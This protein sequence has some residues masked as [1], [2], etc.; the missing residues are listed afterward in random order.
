MWGA[1][2]GFPESVIVDKVT[3]TES[4]KELSKLSEV[5]RLI[6]DILWEVWGDV[7]SLTEIKDP[8]PGIGVNVLKRIVTEDYSRF[9]PM[10]CTVH[11]DYTCSEAEPREHIL[12]CHKCKIRSLRNRY[13]MDILEVVKVSIS[14]NHR[15]LCVFRRQTVDFGAMVPDSNIGDINLALDVFNYPLN[16][17]FLEYDY[18]SLGEVPVNLQ[19]QSAMPHHWVIHYR[20]IRSHP[21]RG[22]S[23][24]GWVER[25]DFLQV[26]EIREIVILHP[27]LARCPLG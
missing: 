23:K 17:V 25:H 27:N 7:N 1:T 6:K 5:E 14:H 19:N 2:S 10:P 13:C 9:M 26:V 18:T 4:E 22:L 20:E 24:H 3:T 11:S 21:H 16:P 8:G 15:T 12:K